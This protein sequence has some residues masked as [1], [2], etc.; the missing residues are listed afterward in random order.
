MATIHGYCDARFGPVRAAFAESFAA[1][2]ELGAGVCAYVEG[3]L[4]VDLWGGFADAAATRPWQRDTIACVAS[5]GKGMAST[6]LLRLVQQGHVDLDAPEPSG[7]A[8][9]DSQGHGY[10]VH[11]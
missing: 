5:T 11:V 7:G 4:V 1:R 10:R 2:G 6:C 9:S 8:A 3:R